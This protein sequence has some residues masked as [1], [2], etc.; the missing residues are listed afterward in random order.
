MPS[1]LRDQCTLLRAMV[2]TGEQENKEG[3]GGRG[4]KREGRSDG[5]RLGTIAPVTIFGKVTN[6]IYTVIA[7]SLTN[8]VCR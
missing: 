4:G 7:Y 1:S 2:C 8:V 3:G 6:I 5:D